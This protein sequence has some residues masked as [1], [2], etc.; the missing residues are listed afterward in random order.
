MKPLEAGDPRSVGG[1]ELLARLGSGGMG[2][3]FLGRAATGHIAALK[4]ARAELA[5]DQEFRRRFAREVDAARRVDGE[6][7]RRRRAPVGGGQGHG[8]AA[9]RG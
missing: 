7:V 9:V 6:G 4:V 8:H 2:V 1:Y 5:D 3:V